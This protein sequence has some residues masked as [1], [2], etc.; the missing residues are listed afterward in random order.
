M[1]CVSLPDKTDLPIHEKV[2]EFVSSANP[3]E[4][5]LYEKF[6]D[7]SYVLGKV[8]SREEANGNIEGYKT[9]SETLYRVTEKGKRLMDFTKDMQRFS[10]RHSEDDAD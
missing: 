5:Q 3:S 10:E 7:Y 1:P 2:I 6:Q 4:R 8:L 9:G